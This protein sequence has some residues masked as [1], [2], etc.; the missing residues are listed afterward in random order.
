LSQGFSV[1]SN[2]T[3]SHCLDLGEGGQDIG[4]AFTIPGNPGFDKGNCGQ[5]RR[6]LLNLSV[7]AQTPKM[8]NG[9]ADNILGHWTGSAIFTA[10]SGSP[11]Q[12]SDG[13]DVSLDG[14]TSVRPN[15]VG[16]P[17][18]AGPVAANPTCVAPTQIHTLAHWYNNCAFV[19]QPTG[20]FGNEQRNNLFGP[21]SW[22]LDAAIWRSFTVMEKY[23]LDFRG[24]G[25]NVLNHANWSNPAAALNTGLPGFI[26]TASNPQRILQVALKLTF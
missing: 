12:M 2:F 5:D 9:L 8:S 20:T 21:G 4:S 23:R 18:V 19:V 1:L 6:K 7:V 14:V 3:W 10:A 16:D 24:E 15:M 22:N 26:S 25:F 17:W 13:T 11:F